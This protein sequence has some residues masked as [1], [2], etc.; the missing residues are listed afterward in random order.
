[1]NNEEISEELIAA[2]KDIG[3]LRESHRNIECRINDVCKEI[4][5]MREKLLKRPSWAILTIITMLSTI[6]ASL[7]VA[8]AL[9]PVR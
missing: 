5:E 4:K 8:I 3:F 1:M 6:C 2:K 7:I 9:L